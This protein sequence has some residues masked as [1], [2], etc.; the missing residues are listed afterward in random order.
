MK[1]DLYFIRQYWKCHKKRAALLLLSYV[2]LI[3]FA[4]VSLSMV[5]TEM[6]RVYHDNFDS[7]DS[8][9]YLA[10][11]S[12]AYNIRMFNI[13]G[14]EYAAMAEDGSVGLIGCEYVGNKLGNKKASLS[15]GAYDGSAAYELS[16]MRLKEGRFPE[17]KGEAAMSERAL[18][19]MGIEA[20]INDSITLSEYN[21]EGADTGSRQFILTGIIRD[22]GT[23]HTRETSVHYDENLEGRPQPSIVFSID[24]IDAESAIRCAMIRFKDGDRLADP[25]MDVSAIHE[26]YRKF[27][28]AD[29]EGLRQKHPV[30]PGGYDS[31]YFAY[32]AEIMGSG[33]EEILSP[34]EYTGVMKNGKAV[35]FEYVCLFAG[36]VMGVSLMCSLM[37]VMPEKMNSYKILEKTGYPLWRIGRMAFLEWILFSLAGLVLGFLA[38]GGIYELILF[39]QW[40]FFGMEP[41][42][43]FFSEWGITMVTHNPSAVSV[44]FS[45]IFSAFSFG[46]S[47]LF[48]RKAVQNKRIKRP[49]AKKTGKS[50]KKFQTNMAK[51]MN[52]PVIRVIQALS[53]SLVLIIGCASSM[54]FSTDGKSDYSNPQISNQ[55]HIFNTREEFDMKKYGIDCVLEYSKP[56]MMLGP[57]LST[58]EAGKSGI[59]VDEEKLF[60]NNSVFSRCFSWTDILSLFVYLPK[61]EAPPEG[62]S[63]YEWKMAESVEADRFVGVEYSTLYSAGAGFIMND[64]MLELLGAD[65]KSMD[66]GRVLIVSAEPGTCLFE[67]MGTLP[68]YTASYEDHNSS[69]SHPVRINKFQAEIGDRICLDEEFQEKEPLL[70]DIVKKFSRPRMLVF[71]M[72]GAGKLGIH[73]KKYHTSYVSYKRG[74]SDKDLKQVF[75]GLTPELSGYKIYTLEEQQSLYE[76]IQI[77]EKIAYYTVFVMFVL[78][79]MTGYAAALKLQAQMCR[80]DVSIFRSVGA[81]KN[82]IKIGIFREFMKIPLAVCTLSW[83]LVKA[84]KFFLKWRYEICL[85]LKE[86]ADSAQ[87]LPDPSFSAENTEAAKIFIETQLKY[88]KQQ[89]AYLTRYEMWKVDT[90]KVYIGLSLFV[91]LFISAASFITARKAADAGIITEKEE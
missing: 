13:S 33:M 41:F 32:A 88:L 15:Y 1:Y 83:I 64:E 62:M 54:F 52:R 38:A 66:E 6:R 26:F 56:D 50:G 91:L 68:L 47:F 42:R 71:S 34:E 77:K 24:E 78:L 72:K 75:S 43:A 70:Y 82:Q 79:S 18:S 84:L 73:Q 81:S 31:S 87:R 35:F 7:E 27:V 11:G 40:R 57:A 23:C 67:D 21:E 19:I 16:G 61:D 36:I 86:T 89:S 80:K 46:V 8:I 2:L 65:V 5:R 63:V 53:L 49:A 59:S 22:D 29:E 4:F 12:G 30:R 60:S 3:V 69:Y 10:N 14:D 39:V 44:C 45:V 51:V 74:I 48:A 90:W 37:I 9:E 85:R 25:A 76:K 58:T 55:G 17:K 20:D 28:Y